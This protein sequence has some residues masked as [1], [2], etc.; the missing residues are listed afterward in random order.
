MGLNTTHGCWDG[1]YSTFM[2]WRKK[3]CEVAGYGHLELRQGFGGSLPWPEDDPLVILLN[4]SDCDGIIESK[5][6]AAIADRLEQVLPAM[7]T[8]QEPRGTLDYGVRTRLFIAGLCEAAK[9]G[10]DVEFH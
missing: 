3:L 7:D 8:A 9:S 4:H 5:D 10:E 2:T 1:S 6:C